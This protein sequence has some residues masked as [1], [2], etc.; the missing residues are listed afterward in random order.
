MV[1]IA[2]FEIDLEK[3]IILDVGV[4]KGDVPFLIN[5]PQHLDGTSFE[6]A[7]VIPSSASYMGVD[8]LLDNS[9]CDHIK[10]NINPWNECTAP[11]RVEKENV[12][13][14]KA[15]YKEI[16]KEVAPTLIVSKIC[17]AFELI[18]L[19]AKNNVNEI[20]LSNQCACEVSDLIN[21]KYFR[22]EGFVPRIKYFFG[23]TDKEAPYS[24][25]IT[26]LVKFL[27][28][29]FEKNGY[30]AERNRRNFYGRKE[31]K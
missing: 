17:G 21:K 28:D 13:F 15:D 31:R 19:A 29:A 20:I 10:H 27:T 6:L 4:C 16:I 30:S 25:T 7:K 11:K 3:Q 23:L 22:Q 9:E 5:D 8:I 1:E 24:Y 2:G 14:E 26:N 12:R 18:K